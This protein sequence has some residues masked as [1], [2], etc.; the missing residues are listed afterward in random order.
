ME[1]KK[2]S[3]VKFWVI[4]IVA[5]GLFIFYFAYN[6]P[7]ITRECI[8]ATCNRMAIVENRKPLSE[9]LKENPYLPDIEEKWPQI[10]EDLKNEWFQKC[11]DEM[12]P[13][14][15]TEK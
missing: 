2:K 13:Y 15:I 10:Q 14:L 4:G 7:H 3:N 11:M 1:E 12:K 6:L 9:G 5:I 8:E